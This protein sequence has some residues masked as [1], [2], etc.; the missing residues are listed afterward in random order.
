MRARVDCY[1]KAFM[2]DNCLKL[3]A[4][5]TVF[6]PFYRYQAEFEPLQLDSEVSIPASYSTRNLGL[7]FDSKLSLKSHRTSVRKS[8]IYIRKR[9]QSVKSVIHAGNSST[10]V[11]N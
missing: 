9:I 10:W 1:F 3:N 5:K 6:I 7:I 4:S 8:A 2:F 11:Y